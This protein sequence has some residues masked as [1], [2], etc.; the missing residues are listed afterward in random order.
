MSLA[1]IGSWALKRSYWER[2]LVWHSIA[3]IQKEVISNLKREN[4][5]LSKEIWGSSWVISR[6]SCKPFYTG[7][8]SLCHN[9]VPLRI[10]TKMYVKGTEACFLTIKTYLEWGSSIRLISKVSKVLLKIL[11]QNAKCGKITL[12]WQSILRFYPFQVSKIVL[13]SDALE[14][15]LGYDTENN[16]IP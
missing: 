13:A 12:S 8:Y 16:T 4:Q 10:W 7:F 15:V 11:F 1:C 2:D 9:G 6:Q 3:Q 14:V 5:F